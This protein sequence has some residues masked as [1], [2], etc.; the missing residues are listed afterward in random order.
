[1]SAEKLL[2]RLHNVKRTRP[3]NFIAGCPCCRSKQ[4]RPIHVTVL[5]DGRILV[6]PFCGCQT[7]D[8]LAALGLSLSDLFP[9]RLPG[10]GPAGG[11]PRIHTLLLPADALAISDHEMLVAV[12][13]IDDIAKA[14]GVTTKA[15]ILR[16]N[17][18]S[19]RIG[20]ARDMACPVKV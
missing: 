2:D 4:G 19:A 9:A 20:K 7:A 3:N 16:L 14:G 10:N 6:N 13:I 17:L 5:D 12:L 18:C 15:Q 11:L 8:V 1:M